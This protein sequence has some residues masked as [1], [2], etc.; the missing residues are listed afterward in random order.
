MRA[1]LPLILLAALAGPV[2][3]AAPDPVD[4]AQAFKDKE[5]CFLLL[6]LKTGKTTVERGEG[7]CAER[8]FA[9]STF[10][11]P[12]ALMAFD[13]GL[14]KNED[15]LI[16]WDHWDRKN[17]YWNRDQTPKTW[18]KYS[19]VWVT[20]R[21]IQKLG[22]EKLKTYLADFRYGSQDMSGGLT[23]AWLNSTLKISPEE[24]LDF[25][26][27]F[28]T[29]KI[30]ASPQAVDLVKKS[31]EPEPSE[32][33]AVLQ[34]KTG[35]GFLDGKSRPGGREVGWYVGHLARADGEYLVVTSF[36]DAVKPADKRPAGERAK[37]LTQLVL[38]KLGLY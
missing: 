26:K 14:L 28:W 8:V 12:V 7:R 22:P 16:K 23:S 10:K 34:G 33:G 13:Q 11:I 29:G 38:G 24:Q 30:A 37:D 9:A 2:R 18:L 20:Q 27:R 25:L 36:S 17:P 35:T 4:W 1:I 6:D 19:T 21:L 15:A 32:R 31:L 5:A 3:A